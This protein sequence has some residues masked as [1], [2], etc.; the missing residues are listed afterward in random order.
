MR[1]AGFLT[2]LFPR[3]FDG[4]VVPGSLSEVI[5]GGLFV[6]AAVALAVFARTHGHLNLTQKS[7]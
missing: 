5:R 6:G 3:A 2:G 4:L 1:L 7:D